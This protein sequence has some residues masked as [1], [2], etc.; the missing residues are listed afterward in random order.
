MRAIVIFSFVA[1][2]CGPV[3]AGDWRQFRGNDSNGVAEESD[4][5]LTWSETENVAWKVPLEG[6]GLSAPIVVGERVFVTCSS[7]FLQDRL[8]V[9]CFDAATGKQRWERRFWATGRTT[10][11]QKTCVAAPTPASDGERVFALFASNDI[12]CLDLDGNLLWYRGLNVDYPNA[13]NSLGMASSP[14]VVGDT[15]I[16]QVES[17]DDAFAVGLDVTSGRERWKIERPRKANWTSPVPLRG[18]TPEQDLAVLQSSAGLAAVV[19]RTG[20]TAWSYGDG[21]STI[22]SSVVLDHTVFTPSGG[23]A[24]IRAGEN[25]SAEVLWKAGNLS[26]STSSPLVYEGHIFTVNSAAVLS[27]AEV[28]TGKRLW[29]LRLE[30]PISSTPVA[31]GGH[32]YLFN[33]KGMGQV[34]KPGAKRGE[35]VGG[36]ELKETLLATPA[37]AGGAIYIRSDDHLWKIAK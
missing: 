16:A 31:S 37:I 12:A 33:E 35:I 11:H 4:L 22:S 6:R 21:A 17:D 10:C 36:G 32:L 20:K 23:I 25:D 13:T 2:V 15:F 28:S 1:A 24:A 14:I 9:L 18:D 34:V 29:Q 5:P 3:A 7:G 26:P 19:P 30:G 27:C 8:H